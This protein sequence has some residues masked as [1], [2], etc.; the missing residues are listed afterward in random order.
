MNAMSIAIVI[1]EA[2]LAVGVILLLAAIVMAF[3]AKNLRIAGALAG[4]GALV[5]LVSLADAVGWI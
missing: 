1:A 2:A 3:G 4:L 5:L